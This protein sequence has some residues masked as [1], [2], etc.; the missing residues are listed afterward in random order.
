[1]AA[2]VASDCH[3]SLDDRAAA[4]VITLMT[5]V[6]TTCGMLILEIKYGLD[7]LKH[8]AEQLK[9]AQSQM[10]QKG[11]KEAKAADQRIEEVL[12]RLDLVLVLVRANAWN[13]SQDRRGSN[14]DPQT[15]LAELTTPSL[16][17]HNSRES[18]AREREAHQTVRSR[19]GPRAA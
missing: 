18:L 4:L 7:G 9:H 19:H 16:E 15:S 12:K 5:A 8:E 2:S 17:Q 6:V 10:K 14:A 3:F 13:N 11:L 1:M